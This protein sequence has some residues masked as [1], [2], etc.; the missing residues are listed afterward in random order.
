M[1]SIRQIFT[2]AQAYSPVGI[3]VA[4]LGTGATFAFFGW[5]RVY[6]NRSEL[7]YLEER[8]KARAKDHTANDRPLH[9]E[10]IASQLHDSRYSTCVK[11]VLN[12][13]QPAEISQP[14]IDFADCTCKTWSS[15]EATFVGNS[16][17]E[18]E[19]IIAVKHAYEEL[20]RARSNFCRETDLLYK[21]VVDFENMTLQ[22]ETLQVRLQAAYKDY[23]HAIVQEIDLPSALRQLREEH[24]NQYTYRLPLLY[25]GIALSLALLS[26]YHLAIGQGMQRIWNL[27]R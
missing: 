4:L 27:V 24:P 11:E 7:D 3:P 6:A 10:F 2:A 22:G 16:P 21:K 1:D 20:K 9:K 14:V 23:R 5:S 17:K 25:L 12:N 18:M 13:L 26:R 19:E 15:M 8:W